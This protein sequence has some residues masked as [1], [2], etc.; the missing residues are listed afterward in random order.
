MAARPKR[1]TLSPTATD[2]DGITTA[3]SPSG[4]VTLNV[5]GSL[6]TQAFDRDGVQTAFT[7]SAAGDFALGANIGAVGVVFSNPQFIT[8]FGGSNESGK[9]F[10]LEGQ[11]PGGRISEQITGPNNSTVFSANMYT[12]I[13]RI[14]VNAATTGDIEVGVNGNAV[15]STPQHVTLT[16]DTDESGETYTIHGIDRQG[17]VTTESLAGPNAGTTTGVKNFAVVTKID[18]P[19]AATNLTAGV[20][21]TCEGPFVSVDLYTD[22]YN[23]QTYVD[24][25]GTIDAD[26]E[27]T[28]EDIYASDF[29]ESSAVVTQEIDGG[30]SDANTN[31]ANPVTALRCKVVSSA[32]GSVEFGVLQVG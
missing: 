26:V 21:G 29:E 20:D 5:N 4:A 9:T 15:F 2:A 25:T 12:K 18:C 6:A 16:A 19:A 30:S 28:L 17:A 24:V 27:S 7:P 14:H 23:V 32:S 13:F 8:I 1:I 31:V 22:E 11:G 3:S 10:L